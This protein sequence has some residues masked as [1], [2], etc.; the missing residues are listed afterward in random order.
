[1]QEG[2]AK[3]LAKDTQ[4]AV[5][6]ATTATPARIGVW[7]QNFRQMMLLQLL[8]LLQPRGRSNFS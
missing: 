3:A 8:D 6:Q 2:S 1:M 5:N 7:L 4:P